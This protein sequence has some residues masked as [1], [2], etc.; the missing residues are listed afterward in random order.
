MDTLYA[1]NLTFSY[2]LK[3]GKSLTWDKFNFKI[4]QGE[5][6]SIIGGSGIG[7]T[8]LLRVLAGLHNTES[9]KL[10]LN[11]PNN[12]VVQPQSPIFIVFQDYN[13][14]LLPWLT[15][16]KNILLGTFKSEEKERI[17]LNDVLEQLFPKMCD[18]EDFLGKYPDELS[19]G[20]R[21]RVQIARAL[22]SNSEFIFFDEPD[23]GIDYKHKLALRRIMLDLCNINSKGIVL[24]THD[25]E[26]AF[27][28]SNR[29]YVIHKINELKTIELLEFDKT[30]EIDFATFKEKIIKYI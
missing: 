13:L 23:T 20:Q 26:N 16:K 10:F 3:D 25:I 7:K 8:T 19:G 14:S 11:N 15:I 4:S 24:I 22:I 2:L 27:E 6:I 29:I 18:F 17:P 30:N 5:V 1:E 28:V 21:Q 9:G 12:K